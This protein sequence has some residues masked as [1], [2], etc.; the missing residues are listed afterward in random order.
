[1]DEKISKL[2]EAT[3]ALVAFIDENEVFDKVA[4]A[5][6]GGID[7]HRSDRFMAVIA[8]AKNALKDLES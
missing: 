6:C 3:K 7:P 2:K 5:G 8:R 4:D 1:M